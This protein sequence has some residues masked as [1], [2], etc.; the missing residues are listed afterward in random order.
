MKWKIV[1][2]SGSTVTSL[3]VTDVAFEIVPLMINIGSQLFIDDEKMD[4]GQLIQA[5]ETS[6]EVSSSA[7]P[8]PSA[9]EQAFQGAE[10]VICFTISSGLSGSYNSAKVAREM[11]LE[12]NPTQNIYVFDTLSAGAEM[13]LLIYKAAELVANGLAFDEVVEALTAYRQHT[14]ISFMLESVDN[15]VKNGRI[16][17]LV[18][19]MIGLL[20]IRLI[21]QKT[22]DGKIEL[23][24]KSKGTKRAM[25]SVAEEMVK[26][27][28]HGG[29]VIVSH[30]DNQEAVELLQANLASQFAN[31]QVESVKMNGL[32]TF[33]AQKHGLIVGYEI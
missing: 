27:G 22:A 4:V 16:N 29:R 20:G 15:L 6:N 10:N 18:G 31:V 1:T 12:A 24:N 19:S 5:M 17:K 13:D 28:Y 23:A 21:G 7:C 11:V 33:Y 32:C 2:D 30:C 14:E 26:K 25:K 9:Y 3:P 8:S